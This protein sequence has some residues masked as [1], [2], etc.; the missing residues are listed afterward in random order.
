M[1]SCFVSG[2]VAVW[3]EEIRSE[4]VHP[5]KEAKK[6]HTVRVFFGSVGDGGGGSDFGH[7]DVVGG[8]RWQRRVSFINL[9]VFGEVPT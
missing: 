1:T 9:S 8:K 7:G 2:K 4:A 6:E 5:A 3:K